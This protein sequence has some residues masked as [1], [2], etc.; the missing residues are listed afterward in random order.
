MMGGQN[1]VKLLYKALFSSAFYFNDITLY[2]IVQ[3]TKFEFNHVVKCSYNLIN[4]IKKELT[5]N[6]QEHD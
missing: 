4:L 2:F 6:T 5:I 1:M 3:F